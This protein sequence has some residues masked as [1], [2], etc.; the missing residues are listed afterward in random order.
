M[1]RYSE[2]NYTDELAVT[3]ARKILREIQAAVPNPREDGLPHPYRHIV[4]CTDEV[5]LASDG[6]VFLKMASFVD[7]TFGSFWVPARMLSSGTKVGVLGDT[8]ELWVQK[9][10]AIYNGWK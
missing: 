5:L 7:A 10:W 1:K 2:L 3:N 6:D 4:R 9:I 8:G